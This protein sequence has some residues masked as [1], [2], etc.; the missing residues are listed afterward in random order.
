MSRPTYADP[1]SP[2]RRRVAAAITAASVVLLVA[3][4]TSNA[5]APGVA[6]VSSSS[7]GSGSPSAGGSSSAQS[8]VA[9]SACMRE[10]GVRSFLDPDSSGNVPKVDPGRLG[11]SSSQ[12]QAAQTACLDLF[13]AGGPLQD[14]TNCLGAGNCPPA[15]VQQILTAERQYAGCMRA[16]GVPNWPDPTMNSRGMPV[17]DTTDAGIDRQFIHSS[18][19]RTPNSECQRVTGGAPAARE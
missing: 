15:L 14:Q 8:A 12:L 19:F 2:H 1:P 5:H 10:H 3:A 9:Y 7:A 17:F 13:P 4:C 11:V 6:A 18:R 16:H